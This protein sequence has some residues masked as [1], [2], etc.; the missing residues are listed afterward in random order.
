[1]GGLFAL[2]CFSFAVDVYYHSRDMDKR[3]WGGMINTLLGY[4]LVGTVSIGQRRY[5]YS[6]AFR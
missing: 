6:V 4:I 1:M 5:E 3:E 2:L